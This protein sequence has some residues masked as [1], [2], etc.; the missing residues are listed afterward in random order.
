MSNRC[1]GPN[2]EA[3]LATGHT[4]CS[5]T[6]EREAQAGTNA[7]RVCLLDDG[8]HDPTPWGEDL[9]ERCA[10]RMAEVRA[11]EPTG[12]CTCGDS[13][14]PGGYDPNCPIDG[15]VTEDHGPGCDGPLNCTCPE[16]R[17][18]PTVE[19]LYPFATDP[20]PATGAATYDALTLRMAVAR[21]ISKRAID[22][23]CAMPEGPMKPR[24]LFVAKAALAIMRAAEA[25]WRS[26][27][28]DAAG[29][30]NTAPVLP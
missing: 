2:C 4:Y 16:E 5:D 15:E 10:T 3:F 25:R 1:S 20:R 24:A 7:T 11:A 18:R 9:C 8:S 30:F 23:Y 21:G 19:P 6:C 28:F 29:N 17:P 26:Q 12:S 22:Y 14:R 13:M 27:A